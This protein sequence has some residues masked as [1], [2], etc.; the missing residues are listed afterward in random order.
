MEGYFYPTSPLTH[1]N[2]HIT[3]NTVTCVCVYSHGRRPGAARG[4]ARL[5]SWHAALAALKFLIAFR[6]L[7]CSSH[8]P[9][10]PSLPHHPPNLPPPLH[11]SHPPKQE[12]AFWPPLKQINEAGEGL[13]TVTSRPDLSHTATYSMS[14]MYAP[15]QHPCLACRSDYICTC[16]RKHT[17]I[18]RW[19]QHLH[20]LGG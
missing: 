7:S 16:T 9:P 19:A 15:T 18:C 8:S 6:S 17:R 13:H 11:H 12:I 3:A 20:F 14:A 10:P 5:A 4:E 1:T 2:T